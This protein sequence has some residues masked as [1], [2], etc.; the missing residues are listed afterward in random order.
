MGKQS[1]NKIIYFDKETIRN[2]LQE[3]EKGQVSTKTDVNATIQS[4]GSIGMEISSK[5]KLDVPFFQISL[6]YKDLAHSIYTPILQ[7]IP[8]PQELSDYGQT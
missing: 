7:D 6:L 3:R 2:I 5:V 8:L 4:Q 1:I